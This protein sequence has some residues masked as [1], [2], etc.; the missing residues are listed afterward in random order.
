MGSLEDTA[1][2]SVRVLSA[3]GP[4]GEDVGQ[5]GRIP[6]VL[7]DTRYKSQDTSCGSQGA[8]GGGDTTSPSS[9]SRFVFARCAACGRGSGRR[10]RANRASTS[11]ST[12]I[13]RCSPVSPAQSALD[14]APS[15]LPP[16]A[17]DKASYSYVYMLLLLSPT[18]VVPC[19]SRPSVR[20]CTHRPLRPLRCSYCR[21]L[22]HVRFPHHRA[23]PATTTT[24][25]TIVPSSQDRTAAILASLPLLLL[26][27]LPTD[28]Y[29]TGTAHHAPSDLGPWPWAVVWNF[30]PELVWRRLHTVVLGDV[31]WWLLTSRALVH[32]TFFVFFFPFV[33]SDVW[34]SN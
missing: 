20:A 28:T 1:R 27:V 22:K 30:L 5:R 3:G 31:G 8:H 17:M 13:C 34:C 24:I 2:V 9:F 25:T 18:S 12:S 11:T 29:D 10:C 23:A 19:V 32:Q 6:F 21:Y 16:R 15:L 26:P 7:H 4:R 14:G 33:S